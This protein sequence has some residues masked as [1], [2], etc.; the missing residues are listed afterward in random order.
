MT[1]SGN[2][3]KLGS[4]N[5]ENQ[6]ILTPTLTKEKL[7]KKSSKRQFP[8]I[9][10]VLL[11]LIFSF[12]LFADLRGQ[13]GE[14]KNERL[15]QLVRAETA[16]VDSTNDSP[17]VE[18]ALDDDDDDD[19]EEL[20]AS[21]SNEYPDNEGDNDD[22]YEEADED[23]ADRQAASERV[24]TWQDE[25]RPAG[26]SQAPSSG[27]QP[28]G[29][30]TRRSAPGEVQPRRIDDISR[31]IELRKQVR[32]PRSRSGSNEDVDFGDDDSWVH[33]GVDNIHIDP[34]TKRA[35][36][37]LA[38]DEANSIDAEYEPNEN[39]NDGA[40]TSG[41]AADEAPTYVNRTRVTTIAE[42]IPV[43]TSDD[44]DNSDG[45]SQA[46]SSSGAYLPA[47]YLTHAQAQALIARSQ[48]R[49]DDEDAD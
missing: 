20:N 40:G 31:R 37:E 34:E 32:K 46:A 10:S 47:A 8:A 3:S 27:N 18:A 33:D 49:R 36:S 16:E 48:R 45:G 22:S 7:A 21:A 24:E 6:N 1:F 23:D 44:G 9:L 28:V 15:I 43:P 2:N 35:A 13:Q 14:E 39:S 26:K 25:T 38:H 41:A 17:S 5:N 4:A 11:I 12:E 19:D 29:R 42:V 30:R